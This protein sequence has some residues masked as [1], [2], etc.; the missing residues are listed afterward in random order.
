[1]KNSI[2]IKNKGF[3]LVEL[4]VVIAI[5]AIL[6]AVLIPSLARF[7]DD[8]RFS[9]DVSKAASMTSVMKAYK[10]E[11][12]GETLDGYDVTQIIND[13]HGE[14]FDF[15]PEASNTGFFYLQNSNRVV[16]LKYEDAEDF[17]D[18]E[19]SIENKTVLLSDVLI[20]GGTD[21]RSP[22]ELF[23]QG[24]HLM[25]TDGSP[26][27]LAVSFIYDLANTGSVIESSYNVGIEMLDDYTSD[28]LIGKIVGLFGFGI[29]SELEDRLKDLVDT[30]DPSKTLFVNNV[31]W[32]TTASGDDAIEK[33]VF[34][35]GISSVPEYV[36]AQGLINEASFTEIE[37]PS[38][39]RTIEANAF[40][41]FT[42]LTSITT[43][44]NR[45]ISV[46]AGAF[47]EAVSI[48][49]VTNSLEDVNLS[50]LYPDLTPIT[51]D[52][53]LDIQMRE[54]QE[55][56]VD[57]GI[58]I[59]GFKIDIYLQNKSNSK[60][61]IYTKDGLIGYVVPSYLLD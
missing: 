46:K 38:T 50:N 41:S 13:H 6:S 5:I 32:T 59:T 11:H 17:V 40:T 23:G 21:Y 25:T 24:K 54:F 47:G 28:T 53:S 19:L 12:Q 52:D 51:Y 42:L 39:V 45:S 58:L 43:K 60:I 49:V 16:A 44:S 33:I 37:L 48:S 26:V 61:Y 15:T 3:T 10:V 1:V 27:A 22:E 2:F 31:G 56:M 14:E 35:R 8:G 20:E 30:Y 7:I 36:L 55:D 34:A 29:S 18:Q 4:I 9:N 57:L